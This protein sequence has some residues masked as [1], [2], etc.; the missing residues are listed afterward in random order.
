MKNRPPLAA[1]GFWFQ[2]EKGLRPCGAKARGIS[3]DDKKDDD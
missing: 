3:T 2:Q 1:K